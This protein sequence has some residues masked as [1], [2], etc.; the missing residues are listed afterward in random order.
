MGRR[1]EARHRESLEPVFDLSTGSLEERNQATIAALERKEPK[2]FQS[3]FIVPAPFAPDVEIVGVP[4]FLLVEGDAYTIRDCKLSRRINEADH[5]EI[6][7]QV[8]LYGWLYERATGSRPARL[9]VVSGPGE[10]VE[11][12]YGGG[13]AA[14]GTLALIHGIYTSGLNQYEPVGRSKCGSCAYNA[15]CWKAAVGAQDPAVLPDVQQG[16]ARLFREMGIRDFAELPNRFTA[17]SLSEL[18]FE[19]ENGPRKVGVVA[20]SILRHAEAFTTGKVLVIGPAR[21]PKS[22]N[23]VMFDLE[24]MPPYLDAPLKIYLWGMQV[25]GA[26]PGPCL[27]PTADFGPDGDRKAWEEFLVNAEAVF[28]QHGDIP[29]V[30]WATYEKTNVTKY[31]ERFGDPKG[32]GAR[33]LANRCDLL[34]ITKKAVVL[35]EPSYSIKIVER[36]AGYRRT[37]DDYGGDWS[38]AQYIKAVETEDEGLRKETIDRIRLYN[39]EDL[40]ATWAV[41]KWMS[42]WSAG[43]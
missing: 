19:R 36:H 41:M 10:T 15:N 25:F 17:E 22:D 40:E 6:T 8:E 5:P 7:A 39:R 24:G 4:D 13:G 33:V 27:Q 42:G 18:R 2:L 16:I 32:V 30:H 43:C 26:A 23:Y 9:Q 31:I 29:F 1:H 14:I 12:P 28:A 21:V 3:V 20:T 34:P 38:M 37:M 35:L 11:L